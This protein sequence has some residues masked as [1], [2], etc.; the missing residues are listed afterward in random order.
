[1]QNFKNH[2]RLTVSYHG[3]TFGATILAL[4][5]SLVILGS[6]GVNFTSVFALSTAVALVWLFI[7]VRQY[8]TLN[9]DRVIRAEENFRCYLLTGKTLDSRLTK[10]QVIAL[11]FADDSEYV[12]LTERAI[13]EKLSAKEIKMSITQWKADYHRI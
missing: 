4:I 12:Q 5:S 7:L 3:I 10:A 1:M 13:N 11:R 9:Q 6:E 8:G 2:T